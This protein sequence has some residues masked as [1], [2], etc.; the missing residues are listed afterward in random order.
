MISMP[1]IVIAATVIPM[2]VYIAIGFRRSSSA[3]TEADYFVYDQKVSI[4]DYAN[5]SVGYALQMAAFFL[6]AYWGALYGLGALWA[7]AFWGMGFWLLV[8]LLPHFLKYHQDASSTMHQYLAKTFSSKRSLQILAAIAT[9]LGLWGTMMAEVDYT[10]QVYAPFVKSL[11]GQYILGGV[12]LIFGLSYI[13]KNGYKA[14]VNTERTQVPIA[15]LAF[16]VILVCILPS[17][18]AYSGVFSYSVIVVVFLLA[19][20]ILFIGKLRVGPRR[21]LKDPQTAIPLAASVAVIAVSI[22][23]VHFP[24]GTHAS[25][26]TQPLSV[27]IYAQGVLGLLSL[28]VANFLWMPVDLSTWQRVASVEGSGDGLL[29]SLKAGTWRVVFE[30][31]ATWV[32][33][34]VLGMCISAGGYLGN[35]GDPAQSLV[36][37]A[38]ALATRNAMASMAVIFPMILYPLFILAS[39]TVML[40][41]VHCMISA[42]SFT[43]YKDLGFLFGTPSLKKAKIMTAFIVLLGMIVYPYLRIRL[44]AN[45]PTILYGAYSAQLSLFV[46]AFLALLK[47]K[48]D[49]KAAVASIS[50]GFAATLISVFF[51]IQ[52]GGAAA[53]VL[54]PIFAVSAAIAGYIFFYRPHASKVSG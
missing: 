2:L 46:V 17:V 39:V 21:A 38:N 3:K 49:A 33:G 45:L 48:L 34:V 19:L 10:I 47:K 9:M 13:V 31:P 7:P 42:I 30:S 1:N 28:F 41:T 32:L 40:S 35:A 52:T 20:A 26:L 22:Y 37:F 11:P 14:E 50:F 6:F 4:E 43:A 8:R 23:V 12:F 18:W 27:Q 25:V 15:Y 53:A 44:G 16:I 54:P 5:T 51:A 36:L 29:K 24:Q